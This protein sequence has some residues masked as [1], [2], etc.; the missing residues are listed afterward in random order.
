MVLQPNHGGELHLI[1]RPTNTMFQTKRRKNVD[2]RVGNISK[3]ILPETEKA[4]LLLE[5]FT[6]PRFIIYNS[7][8]TWL[9]RFMILQF[10]A[11]CIS[12]ILQF[13]A[14]GEIQWLNPENEKIGN[15]F[16]NKVQDPNAVNDSE[17]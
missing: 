13:V 12:L 5:Q 10:V 4:F 14:T 17:T 6:R 1:P 11:T 2:Q 16:I 8:Y 3:I 9:G 7:F 15:F